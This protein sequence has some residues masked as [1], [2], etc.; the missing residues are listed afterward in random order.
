MSYLN[1]FSCK[2]QI[3]AQFHASLGKITWQKNLSVALVQVK[4]VTAF[5][6]QVTSTVIRGHQ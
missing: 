5:T 6:L 4:A 2:T 1:M 3:S